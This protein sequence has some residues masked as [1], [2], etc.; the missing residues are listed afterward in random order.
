M[1]SKQEYLGNVSIGYTKYFDEHGNLTQVIDEDRKF[2][3]V[4]PKD[5]VNIMEEAGLFNR[6]TGENI[7]LGKTLKTDG[8]FYFELIRKLNIYFNPAQYS[9]DGKEISPPCWVFSYLYF[10]TRIEYIINGNTGEYQ[11]YET[12]Q[13]MIE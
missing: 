11:R 5:V 4:K 6:E 7:V 12:K 10:T 8:S 13:E 3:K 2:G 9:Q 1:K